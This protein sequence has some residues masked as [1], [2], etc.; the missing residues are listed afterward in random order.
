MRERADSD[1]VGFLDLPEVVLGL[2]PQPDFRR[3]R[4]EGGSQPDSHLRRDG[5]L[6]V[7]NAR[8]GDAAHAE[9]HGREKSK[10]GVEREL[11]R[12]FDHI[13]LN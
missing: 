10:Q 5:G 12:S 3:G 7:Q 6:A 8:K 13:A 4:A 2:H 1:P 9:M 11:T